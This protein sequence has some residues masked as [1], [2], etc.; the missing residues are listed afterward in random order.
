M[1]AK[2]VLRNKKIK[3]IS[4]WHFPEI[5]RNYKEK[6]EINFPFV[7]LKESLFYFISRENKC[8]SSAV[9]GD[10]MKQRVWWKLFLLFNNELGSSWSGPEDTDIGGRDSL[11]YSNQSVYPHC[12]PSNAN[13]RKKKK[14]IFPSNAIIKLLFSW[15]Y[16]W[17]EGGFF[18]HQRQSRFCSFWTCPSRLEMSQLACNACPSS[19]SEHF[20]CFLSNRWC[21]YAKKGTANTSQSCSPFFFLKTALDVLR[22]V[23]VVALS[24]KE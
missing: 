15:Q 10:R 9:S 12:K 4:S 8:P 11:G 7:I 21:H 1:S 16:W 20:K 3:N 2:E 23:V 6:K 24:T 14:V 5:W 19:S 18:S 22:I 13:T 17:V